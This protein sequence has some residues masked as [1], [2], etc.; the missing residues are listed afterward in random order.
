MNTVINAW[1]GEGFLSAAAIILMGMMGMYQDALAPSEQMHLRVLDLAEN[2]NDD[3]RRKA[4]GNAYQKYYSVLF[5]REPEMVFDPLSIRDIT[6]TAYNP[7]ESAT[8]ETKFRDSSLLSLG[9]TRQDAA[10]EIRKGIY[11]KPWLGEMY[12][13]DVKFGKLYE[14]FH[15]TELIII[16]CGGYR[17]GGTASTFIPLENAS[18]LPAHIHGHRYVVVAGPATQFVHSV[19]I[20]YPEIYHI[21]SERLRDVDVFDVEK[22]IDKLTNDCVSPENY[23]KH[24]KNIAFLKKEWS[25]VQSSERDLRNL[26]P[27]YYASRFLDRIASDSS[28]VSA[29]FSACSKSSKR[30]Y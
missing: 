29:I 28:R 14:N 8:I 12:Y 18:P 16:N 6:S 1:G 5:R 4:L 21:K 30:L 20:P 7:S 2:S 26:N 19:T 23:E 10:L 25:M 27:K 13:A 9:C 15:Q 11:G 17:G 3:M 22:L 24:E